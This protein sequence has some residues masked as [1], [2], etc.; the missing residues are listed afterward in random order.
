MQNKICSI[1]RM[2]FW[3]LVFCSLFF[4]S[5]Q[6]V[7]ISP[8]GNKHRLSNMPTYEQSQHFFLLGLIGNKFV[9]VSSI[10]GDREVLQM[11]TQS[12]FLNA[13]LYGITLGIYTPRT[14]KVW[15]SK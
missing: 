15:C 8:S 5:C 3:M 7:T 13:F 6:T 11:Q 12:T 1:P 9:N 2:K 14:A 4:I 10:C